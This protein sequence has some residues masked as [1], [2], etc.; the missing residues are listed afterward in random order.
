MDVLRPQLGRTNT[1]VDNI[2][3]LV[4]VV[5]QR[6]YKNKKKYF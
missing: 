3:G 6:T 4:V 2:R 5:V 1:V